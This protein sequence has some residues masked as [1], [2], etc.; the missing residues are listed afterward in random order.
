MTIERDKRPRFWA[1]YDADGA[2]ICVCVYRQGD[3]E[4]DRRLGLPAA[5][6]DWCWQCKA[7]LPAV[8]DAASPCPH[9]GADLLLL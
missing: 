3:E 6:T 9:C 2:L 1:V 8:A 7:E 4:V 5:A